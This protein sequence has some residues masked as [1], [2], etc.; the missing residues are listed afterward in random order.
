MG[1]SVGSSGRS[2]RPTYRAGQTA[3][4]IE[5][6]FEAIADQL[7]RSE[8]L[9]VAIPSRRTRG[10]NNDSPPNGIVH[11]PGRTEAE[12]RKFGTKLFET[13]KLA[14]TRIQQGS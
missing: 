7:S 11:F 5:V 6:L 10:E 8:T 4:K 14:L 2:N 1:D 13:G 3:S 12:S 9:T